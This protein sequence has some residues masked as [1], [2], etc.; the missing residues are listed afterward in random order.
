METAVGNDPW[1]QR[2]A[3]GQMTDSNGGEQMT[4]AERSRTN[5]TSSEIKISTTIGTLTRELA[6]VFD[7]HDLNRGELLAMQRGIK[8]LDRCSMA[9]RAN[10][11]WEVTAQPRAQRL[12]D[13]AV[14]VIDRHAKAL[15]EVRATARP[16][17]LDDRFI[18]ALPSLDA[19]NDLG[20]WWQRRL[21]RTAMLT[22]LPALA[23]KV[24][25]E[26]ELVIS[27]HEMAL[28]DA[29]PWCHGDRL[30]SAFELAH[31]EIR[32]HGRA[33]VTELSVD[34]PSRCSRP[35]VQL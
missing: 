31:S 26:A 25:A 32:R 1:E 13:N 18:A 7:A 14:P 30:L 35:L 6:T 10:E 17:D 20:H 12:I 16:D 5:H 3:H 8:R 23:M 19:I 22:S 34:V 11:F 27:N 2:M 15:A 33:R 21:R 4:R 28:L 24:A 29:A 9:P